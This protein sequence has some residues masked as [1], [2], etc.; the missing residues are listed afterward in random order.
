MALIAQT[1][2]STGIKLKKIVSTGTNTL[3]AGNYIYEGTSGN[4]TLKFFSHPEGYVDVPSGY[5]YVYQYKDHLGNVRLSYRDNSGSLEI[6]EENNYYP[7]GLKHK[8]YN[9]VPTAFANIALKRKF[10]GKEYQDE[11]GLNWYDI[12]AR[13]YDPALGRWMNVDPLA[14]QMRR[15]SPYNYA[16]NNPL[17]FIDPDGMSP[18]DVIITGEEREKALSELQASVE[19]EINLKMDENG[20]VNYELATVRPLSKGAQQLVDA[21]SDSEVVVNL[22]AIDSGE[23]LI[24]G[25]FDGNKTDENGIVHTEQTV[26]PNKTSIID[27]TSNDSGTTVL[28]EVVESYIGGKEAKNRGVTKVGAATYEDRMNKKSIFYKAHTEAPQPKGKIYIDPENKIIY[29]KAPKREHER[30]GRRVLI[31][32]Y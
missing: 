26:D 1:Y 29:T 5:K 6:L 12:T 30:S 31:S 11:L 15:H 19:G 10:G 8:G 2:S 9:D 13:N 23:S 21:I 17:R 25:T 4:E 3:Y 32:K 28:H 7:F 14:E 24:V 18:N 16:F 20:K 27:E 22:N